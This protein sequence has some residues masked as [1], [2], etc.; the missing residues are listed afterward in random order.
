[1]KHLLLS[2]L[3]LSSITV[4]AQADL[5][6]R[7]NPSNSS[8]SYVYV[9]DVVLYVEDNVNLERNNQP[10]TE[11]SIYLRNN[12]QL[13][14]GDDAEYN[15]GDGLLSVYQRAEDSDQ[16]TYNYWCYPVGNA[17]ATTNTN[18]WSGVPRIYDIQIGDP[19]EVT[20]STLA[21]TT[22]GRN[23][24]SGPLTIS[25]RWI[26]THP[27]G[28]EAASDYVRV[29]GSNGVR[30]GFGFTM[31]GV[32][33]SPVGGGG[34]DY[35]PGFEYDF[36][37][38]PNTGEIIV[39]VFYDPI[40]GDGEYTLSGNPYPSAL[41]L[42]RLFWDSDN[43]DGGNPKLDRILFWD[44][45]KTA[46][47]HY[48][49]DNAGGYGSWVPGPSD[50]NG[51]NPG[52][53]T[54]PTFSIWRQDGTV[55]TNTGPGGPIGLERR[56]APIGQGFFFVPATSDGN[57]H[58]KNSF[59]RFIPYG[60]N[61]SIFRRPD[62]ANT[63]DVTST[64]NKAVSDGSSSGAV[65]VS[66]DTRIPQIR[67]NTFFD[68]SHIREMLLAFSDEATDGYDRG[69]DAKSPMD[70]SSE[71][72][73]LLGQDDNRQPYVIN[74]VPFNANK[75]IPLGLKLDRFF[76]VSIKVVEAVKMQGRKAY[77][78]DSEQ[79]TFQEFT[80]GRSATFNLPAGTYDNRFFVVFQ[81]EKESLNT[82]KEIQGRTAETV[83]FYQNN[84]LGVLE[85]SNPEGHDI[86]QAL[87]FD[88]TGKLVFEKANIGTEKRFSFPTSNLSD[89]VYLVK[90]QTVDNV[91][92]S[93]KTSVYNKN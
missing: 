63:D 74:S 16:W 28:R 4:T 55:V 40:L 61:G 78:F 15:T 84:R 37:G 57:I 48:Y 83:E 50:P 86:K 12:A 87:V 38:R 29:G 3:V 41:D 90:L 18:T 31:K 45:D 11:G 60:T 7:P 93:Y 53:Y 81:D 76:K 88:M 70:A 24:S 73:F 36:R 21:N 59:R 66:E 34:S 39:P 33:A 64:S 46:N 54:R 2:L 10:E 14:Q 43:M 1:M 32:D 91:D 52:F 65:I 77:I 79:K 9:N 17:N 80:N 51:T 49:S 67:I 69:F 58:I 68:K 25:T 71:S 26:Y 85:V 42:N 27:R 5:F 47:S 35:G 72:Y 82:I 8:D 75:Q 62:K 56:F 44:E 20:Y 89:G 6:V 23:G 92:I 30:P 22:S 19:D 13:I